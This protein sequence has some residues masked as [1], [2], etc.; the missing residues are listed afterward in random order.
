MLLALLTPA[1]AADGWTLRGGAHL[2]PA[3]MGVVDVAYARGPWTFGLYTDTLEARLSPSGEHGRAW[4]A[5]RGEFGVAGLMTSPWT[6]GAPDPGRARLASYAGV[7]GGAIRYGAGGLYAG[8]QAVARWWV[9][10][11]VE[12]TTIAVAPDHAVLGADGIVGLW[13][14]E[15][16]VWARVGLDLEPG[17]NPAQPHAALEGVFDPGG[18]VG[19]RVEVRAGLASNQTDVTRTRLGGLSPYVVPLAGAV[20]AEWWA[21]DYMAVRGAL[22][23]RR[24]PWETAFFVDGATFDGEG[25]G[26]LGL[27]VTWR[28]KAW[29]VETAAGASP[30]LAR[31]EG[32]RPLDGW[33]RVGW[34]SAKR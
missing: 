15:A 22:V 29:T 19:P 8:G 31:E 21:E 26:G 4:V 27:G 33:L 7:E 5:A 30:W 23:G 34:E 6:D 1:L 9:F 16:H 3:S 28:K 24:G 20:W 14:P 25:A 11:P 32:V 13:R 12:T 18:R 2:A 10:S 17:Q